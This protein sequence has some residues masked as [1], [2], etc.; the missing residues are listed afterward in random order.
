MRKVG[1]GI[2][3]GGVTSEKPVQQVRQNNIFFG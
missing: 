1:R 2:G 3:T